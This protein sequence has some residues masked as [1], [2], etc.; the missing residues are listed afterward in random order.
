MA[1]F[2]PQSPSTIEAN[3]LR[4]KRKA[5]RFERKYLDKAGKMQHG[6]ARALRR[7][8]KNM[9]TFKALQKARLQKQ[10]GTIQGKAP[11]L[12]RVMATLEQQVEG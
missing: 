12:R 3:R 1:K 4:R 10:A 9:P 11:Q 6:A 8:P 7:S 2:K 5:L